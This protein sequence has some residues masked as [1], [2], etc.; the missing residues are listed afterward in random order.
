MIV[1]TPGY[2]QVIDIHKV[3]SGQFMQ[4]VFL[5]ATIASFGNKIHVPCWKMIINSLLEQEVNIA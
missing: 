3:F 1:K 4:L 2:P 5:P